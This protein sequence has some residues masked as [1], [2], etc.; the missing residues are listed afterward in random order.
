M[1]CDIYIILQFSF[2]HS[3]EFALVYE[4][5]VSKIEISIFLLFLVF[6]L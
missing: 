4:K 6:L 5:K 1:K 3:K 2:S